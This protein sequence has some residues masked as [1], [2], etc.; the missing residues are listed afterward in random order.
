L[1]VI[2][3]P[4]KIIAP[5]AAE[6]WLQACVALLVVTTV[7]YLLVRYSAFNRAPVY[8]E[9]RRQTGDLNT[10]FGALWFMYGALL[11]QGA[12]ANKC[13]DNITRTFILRPKQR[14]KYEGSVINSSQHKKEN[15]LVYTS[16]D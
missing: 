14:V 4:R 8:A 5:L 12:W 15:Q 2:A 9:E 6:F 13:T 3:P 1:Y 7:T 11:F 16:R 10:W